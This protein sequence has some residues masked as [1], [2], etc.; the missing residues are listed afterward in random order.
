MGDINVAVKGTL[1]KYYEEVLH[2]TL[3]WAVEKGKITLHIP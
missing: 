3:D 2:G 1:Q